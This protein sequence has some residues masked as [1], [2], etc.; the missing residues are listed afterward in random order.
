MKKAMFIRIMA[1]L[2]IVGLLLP[3][4]KKSGEKTET[5]KETPAEKEAKAEKPAQKG[6][7]QLVYVEWADAVAATN[8]VQVVLERM[9]YEVE[10]TSVSA[11]AMWQSVAAGDVDGMVAAW[12]PVTH[13][14][15]YEKVKGKAVNLGPNLEGAKIGLVVP[16]YVTINTI[17]ELKENADKFDNRIIGIDPGAGIMSKTEKAIE[18]YDLGMNLVSGS[19]A[20]MTAALAGAVKNEEWIVVTGWKPHW[21][22]AR[23]DLKFLKDPRKVYGGTE[24][25]STVVRKGLKEDMPVVYKFLD[26]FKWTTAQIEEL[27]LMNRENAQ[28]Y[29]NAKKWVNNNMDIVQKWLPEGT[30]LK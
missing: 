22:F 23:W 10:S 26:N 4:C 2:C 7:V 11:A 8:V 29:E 17:P 19:G 20:T 16:S 18:E 27:M 24:H 14:H 12:L 5:A 21:K 1:L 30:S 25:V 28:P 6:K 9:G 13:H 3:A 15:Y